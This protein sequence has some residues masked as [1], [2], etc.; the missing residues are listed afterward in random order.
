LSKLFLNSS[1]PQSI[2]KAALAVQTRNLNIHEYQ[3]QDLMRKYGISVP[4]GELATSLE[5]AKSI[6]KKFGKDDYIIKSQILA[7][8]RGRG[9]FTNGFKGGVHL[10]TTQEEFETVTS[11]M[12]GQTLVTKQ[13][14]PSG[15]LVNKVLIAER[16]YIRREA[17]FAILLDRKSSNVVMVGSKYGGMD[18][19]TVAHDTPEAIVKVPVK[20]SEGV[21]DEQCR[22]MARAL[23]FPPSLEGKLIDQIKCLYNMF[24]ST[25]ATQV[26][27]N[28]FVETAN[29]EVMCMDAKINFDDNAAYRQKE[30]F[31]LRDYTQEDSREVEASKFDLNYIG[32]DG[33]IGCLV[34]GAGLAM[35]TMDIIQLNGGVPANF[36]DVGGGASAKQVTEA[37]KII[38]SDP[39]VKAI[40]V[41]IFGGIMRC[42][43]IAT[44]ILNAVS[45]LDLKTP[46]V[47]R[48]SGTNVEEAKK[49]LNESSLKVISA[50]C[51]GE[52]AKKVVKVAN[53]IQ[54][55][56]CANL[57]V[58][59]HST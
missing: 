18:I 49:L 7:G 43:V 42:D 20:I 4:R 12:L 56:E 35:A 29:G 13:T 33:N 47:V 21:N 1:V 3:S 11:K 30:I 50:D 19:E 16:H 55:A 17:Y 24:I 22:T 36:L 15:Q 2:G 34:N 59:L 41:N 52:A 31:Q 40:L 48:L 26:E 32:L 46:L 37:L 6:S 51:L 25:D 54:M 9:T 39:N 8:G 57:K 38:A 10:T 28:P 27:I 45:V 44:G 53:I 14:G 5:E 23:G 58:T